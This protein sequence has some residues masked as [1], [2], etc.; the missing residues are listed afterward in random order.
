MSARAATRPKRPVD[1]HEQHQHQPEPEERGEQPAPQRAQAQRRADRGLGDD[2]HVHRQRA[3][4]E[5]GLQLRALRPRGAL[6]QAVVGDRD[7]V[8]QTVS[9]PRARSGRPGRGRWRAARLP[10]DGRPSL[11]ISW[12]RSAI[13][14]PPSAGE[15]QRDDPLV[16]RGRTR[17]SR[18]SASQR[19][20][21][22]VGLLGGRRSPTTIG[23]APWWRGLSS[24]RILVSPSSKAWSSLRSSSI[25]ALTSLDLVRRRSGCSVGGEDLVEAELGRAADDVDDLV[26]VLDAGDLDDYLVWP[27]T[28]TSGSATPRRSMR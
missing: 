28:R 26:R 13:C 3:G 12:V 20:A 10:A 21:R 8:R 7:L 18:R 24:K 5:H 22:K 25:S 23:P 27:C 9:S 4:V 17:R 15:L 19:L 14:S 1:D 16:L 6:G 11:I 2:L